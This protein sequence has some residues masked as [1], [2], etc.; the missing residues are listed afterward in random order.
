MLSGAQTEEEAACVR[1]HLIVPEQ[2]I[3][4]NICKDD[5]KTEII[6][7]T[8]QSND[9]CIKSDLDAPVQE[10]CDG[11]SIDGSLN[12]E[13]EILD[14]YSSQ[15]TRGAN[16]SYNTQHSQREVSNY[17][18]VEP[19]L[20]AG[21]NF[22]SIFAS[23]SQEQQLCLN[24]NFD[25]ESDDVLFHSINFKN[26][27]LADCA[28]Q[29]NKNVACESYRELTTEEKQ[30]ICQKC[31]K[32]FSQNSQKITVLQTRCLPGMCKSFLCQIK[33][34]YKTN[35]SYGA[36]NA[37]FIRNLVKAFPSSHTKEFIQ[38][39]KHLFVESVEKVSLQVFHA[40]TSAGP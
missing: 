36:D 32:G 18:F 5:I 37:I 40:K 8:E 2:N 12:Q 35:N 39:R 21:D 11:I 17:S 4:N 30:Y 16:N 6:L 9:L 25:N 19:I 22:E 23:S 1:R 14:V 3:C 7:N 34:G 38:G 33:S 20:C 28:K 27:D 31:G 24:N 26:E 29:I 15:R 10:V 13:D